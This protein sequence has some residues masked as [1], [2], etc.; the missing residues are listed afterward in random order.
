MMKERPIL[1]SSAMIQA[2]LAGKKFQTRRVIK[3]NGSEEVIDGML[4]RPDMYGDWYPIMDYCPY[5]NHMHLWVRE[6]WTLWDAMTDEWEGELHKGPVPKCKNDS[7]VRFWKKRV[8]YRVGEPYGS[9]LTW[10]P[11][12]FMPRWASRITLEITD[13]RAQRV[14]DISEEDAQAEGCD[15]YINPSGLCTENP[16]DYMLPPD[17]WRNG[18]AKLWDS[19]NAAR[20]YSWE[21]NCWVWALTFRRIA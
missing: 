15:A 18:F 2:I 1:F 14:Q 17:T 10:R 8:S 3:L 11:S 13:R 7:D 21:S 9:D 12:I 4:W 19:I 5:H 6:T 16:R 20:G